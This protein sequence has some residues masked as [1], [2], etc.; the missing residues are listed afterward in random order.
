[1]AIQQIEK[2]VTVDEIKSAIE[3]VLEKTKGIKATPEERAQIKKQECVAQAT[4]L[5]NRYLA[6]EERAEDVMGLLKDNPPLREEF[7]SLLWAKIE[8]IED[9]DPMIIEAIGVFEGDGHQIADR[10]QGL[11][12][13]YREARQKKIEELNEEILKRLSQKGILGNAIRPNPEGTEEGARSLSRIERDYSAK[14][15]ELK[16]SLNR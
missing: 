14:L 12:R 9:L 8:G 11:Y 5:L 1:M 4:S 2:E 16:A 3:L 15:R 7:L 6:R 10:L 13:E